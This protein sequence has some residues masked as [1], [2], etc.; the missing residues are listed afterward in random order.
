M[1][2]WLR[3]SDDRLSDAS[4]S[5]CASPCRSRPK[6]PPSYPVRVEWN[7]MREASRRVIGLVHLLFD[8]IVGLFVVA[9][10]TPF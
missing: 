2:G 6:A 8:I 9:A 10:T 1:R 4:E 5:V 3:D 7:P